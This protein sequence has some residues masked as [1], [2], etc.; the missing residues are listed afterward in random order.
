MINN[1]IPYFIAE[2]EQERKALDI[3]PVPLLKCKAGDYILSKNGYYIPVL[4]RSTHT[5][6]SRGR[7]IP[8]E[9]I[10]LPNY[11]LFVQN[12]NLS[13]TFTFKRDRVVSHI[14]ISPKM[15]TVLILIRSGVPYDL[16]IK[17]IYG[18]KNMQKKVYSLLNN[19]RFIS[20]MK[21]EIM[22]LQ[23]ELGKQGVTLATIAEQFSNL[24]KDPKAN[25]TLKKYALEVSLKALDQS[26]PE[27]AASG[28]N[29]KDEIKQEM[30]LVAN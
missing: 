22:S 16:A 26:A 29:L 6:F 1:N 10:V 18:A 15:R 11:A 3:K 20:M 14:N 13:T 9:K 5:R 2:N 28:A 21:D 12:I 25:S 24:I 30:K 19:N 8:F 7:K 27:L 4:D 23:K 17:T